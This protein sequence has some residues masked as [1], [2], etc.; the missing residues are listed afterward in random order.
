MIGLWGDAPFIQPAKRAIPVALNNT[1]LSQSEWLGDGDTIRIGSASIRCEMHVDELRLL[2]QHTPASDDTPAARV[3]PPHDIEARIEPVAFSTTSLSK[4]QS[5]RSRKVLETL[6]AGLFAG[7]L[8]L[9]WFVFTATPVLVQ[10]DPMPERIEFTGGLLTPKIGARYLLRPGRYV[11]TAEK[12]GYL[13]LAEPVE[14][15]AKPNQQISFTLEKLPG[16]L[17]ITTRPR[18]AARVAIDGRAVGVTP[19]TDAELSPGSHEVVVQAARYLE[20]RTDVDIEGALAKQTLDITLTPA[21]APVSFS[22]SPTGASLL[23]DGEEVGK[24]PLTT[25]LMAGTYV[26]EARNEGYDTWSTELI[27]VANQPQAV[28]DIV[29][30]KAGA[31]LTLRSEPVGA[32]VTVAGQFRGQTPLVL[33]LRPDEAHEIT[34]SKAGYKTVARTIRVEPGE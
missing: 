14:I 34:L 23:V 5:R 21:W 6:F 27:V 9:A 29:L 28:P 16:L 31:T 7:L 18:I 2:L 24:T 4:T 26:L 25:D 20:V 22:S 3:I 11:L 1:R 12:A 32:T 17:S 13:P 15:F 8:F 19:L 30:E 10:I 33:P